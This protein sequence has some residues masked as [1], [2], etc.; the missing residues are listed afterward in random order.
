MWI[1]KNNFYV[2][3]EKFCYE[4]NVLETKIKLFLFL[5]NFLTTYEQ[6]I[7]NNPQEL[8]KSM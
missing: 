1:K 5:H 2:I 4:G 6:V 3:N 7:Y 8:L